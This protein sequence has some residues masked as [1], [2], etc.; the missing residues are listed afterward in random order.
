[1]LVGD[2]GWFELSYDDYD[3]ELVSARL[4]MEWRPFK[5]SGLGLG[6]QYIDVAVDRDTS[7]KVDK[8]RLEFTG[9]II[10]FSWGF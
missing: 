1:M 8:Y 9:P 5:R 4:K 6:Y 2:I 7:R 3:G 10:Y